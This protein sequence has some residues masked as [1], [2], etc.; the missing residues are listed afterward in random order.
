MFKKLH[1]RIDEYINSSVKFHITEQ[2]HRK[3]DFGEGVY[4]PSRFSAFDDL[5]IDSVDYPDWD[6]GTDFGIL[7]VRGDERD[8]DLSPVYVDREKLE[9]IMMG[10]L[11]YN[12]HFNK[13]KLVLSDVVE[14]L[15]LWEKR[16]V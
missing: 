5:D 9:K 2:S 8:E 1:I 16:N 11:K 7:Y 3:D 14:N 15:E 4:H 13:N 10:I 6:G 12:Q